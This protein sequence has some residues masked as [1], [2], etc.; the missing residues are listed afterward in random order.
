MINSDDRVA[1]DRRIVPAHVRPTE[2]AYPTTAFHPSGVGLQTTRLRTLR[3]SAVSAFSV[4][5]QIIQS[6]VRTGADQ[7]L[8][9][10]FAFR[11]S[12]K[13]FRLGEP[14]QIETAKRISTKPPTLRAKPFTKARV[15]HRQ[16][17]QRTSRCRSDYNFAHVQFYEP[18]PDHSY[19]AIVAFGEGAGC[20]IYD[21]AF[22]YSIITIGSSIRSLSMRS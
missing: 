6:L 12:R 22:D 7:C 2:L 20:L 11:A 18:W 17:Q 3:P 9:D 8:G 16:D 21:F 1:N 13:T 10:F 19:T 14:E 15:L 5:Q 4:F